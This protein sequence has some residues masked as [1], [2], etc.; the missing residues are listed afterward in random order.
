L[1]NLDSISFFLFLDVLG[2]R[3]IPGALHMAQ[4]IAELKRELEKMRVQNM[5]SEQLENEIEMLRKRLEETKNSAENMQETIDSLQHEN[6]Q[7]VEKNKIL[8]LSSSE[9]DK[10]L[11]ENK[12]LSSMLSENLQKVVASEDALRVFLTYFI[13]RF[14]YQLLLFYAVFD[15]LQITLLWFPIVHKE[16][17][18]GS[19]ILLEIGRQLHMF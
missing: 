11:E 3:L 16:G 7:L 19:T 17:G 1:Q 5:K 18:S 2:F 4:E 9:K 12:S 14:L 13:L 8:L 10:L 6:G 15:F